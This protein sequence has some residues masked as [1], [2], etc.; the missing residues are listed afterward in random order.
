MFF[1]RMLLCGSGCNRCDSPCVHTSGALDAGVPEETLEEATD[2][3]DPKEQ[4]VSILLEVERSSNRSTAAGSQ[5][6]L[7]ALRLE[8]TQLKL[9]ALRKRAMA[10]S[11]DSQALDE[12]DDSDDPKAAVVALL[13]E[14]HRA[15]GAGAALE[16]AQLLEEL[17]P[18]KLSALRKRA[19]AGGV[20]SAAIEAV[21]D[22]DDPKE[23]LIELLI[24]QPTRE[25]A[26]A[27]VPSARRPH[28]GAAAESTPPPSTGGRKQAEAASLVPHGKHVM[29]SYQWDVQKEVLEV[30]SKL[31]G[32]RVNSW[33]DVD[34]GMQQ[35]LYDS[36]AEGVQNAC[37]VVCFMTKAYET[38]ENCRLELQFAKQL[39]VPIVP[40]LAETGYTASGWLGIVTAGA[41]WVPLAEPAAF[42]AGVRQLVQ[43]I[44]IAVPEEELQP[45][46]H[47]SPGDALSIADDQLFTP[48]EV[49]A[50][51]D[52]LRTDLDGTSMKPVAA[53]M[54]SG[55]SGLCQL[56]AGVGVLLSGLRVS[57]EMQQ[58]AKA[59]V[60]PRSRARVGFVGMGGVGKT[61][62]SAWLVRREDVRQQFDQIAW[63]PLGQ[64]PNVLKCQ[65]LLY[66]QLTG[67]EMVPGLTS[68]QRREKLQRAMIGVNVLVVLDDL[69]ENEHAHA[70][71]LIDESTGAKVLISSRVR[72]LL[73][74]ADIVDIGLPSEDEAISMLMA[75]AGAPADLEPPPEARDVVRFCKCLPLSI[76]IAGKLVADL[77]FGD[78]N[79]D[80]AGVLEML[81]DEFEQNGQTRTIE[82][83]VIAASLRSIGGARRENIVNLFMAMALIPEDVF[84][85]LDILAM[86][87]E[88]EVSG[89]D[90]DGRGSVGGSH[91]P[92]LLKLRRWLKIL[93]DR[94]LVLG[95]VDRPSLHDIPRDFCIGQHTANQ[96]EA[97]HRRLVDIFRS[98]RPVNVHGI[99]RWDFL[100]SPAA[101]YVHTYAKEHIKHGRGLE[102]WT[103][104]VLLDMPQDDLVLAAARTVDVEHLASSAADA[105]AKGEWWNSARRWALVRYLRYVEEGLMAVTEPVERTLNALDQLEQTCGQKEIAE[106]VDDIE[107]IRFEQLIS[108]LLTINTPLVL[109]RTPDVQ[110]ALQT[111]VAARNP[112]GAAI[113]RNCVELMPIL[114]DGNFVRCGAIL[115]GTCT[116][117]LEAAKTALDSNTRYRALLQA[118]NQSVLYIDILLLQDGF[119]WDTLFGPGGSN[120]MEASRSYSF[121]KIHAFLIS[122]W[123]IDS[124]GMTP[125]ASVPLAIHFEDMPAAIENMVRDDMR[126][127]KE[128]MQPCLIRHLLLI[129]HVIS[130]G[131]TTH[132]KSFFPSLG[133][134]IQQHPQE[135]EI[136]HSKRRSWHAHDW[137]STRNSLQVS[138][139]YTIY[140]IQ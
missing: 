81:Q 46:A 70:L 58:L 8:L 38:S 43:Q 94:S 116:D 130:F 113:L 91:R 119:G 82:E 1:C 111:A 5:G 86:I 85:P 139:S 95:T 13:L 2:A 117:L 120:I 71:D 103:A 7:D 50:E 26:V 124:V 77:Q 90:S 108:L 138:P 69:W 40:V 134:V 125:C 30:Q 129:V 61:T 17:T 67:A 96:L 107:E 47:G 57:P 52:R 45:A 79:D 10:E 23:A 53:D 127:T 63:I 34:G 104:E 29:L 123:N 109:A 18:M 100:I 28:F 97:A 25:A 102:D 99:Q 19:L 35:N 6:M 33:V 48:G 72:A 132:L 4:V 105:D 49:R 14:K 114:G 133:T 65:E 27:A 89:N 76:G 73:A 20:E 106:L 128:M 12:A 112:C 131:A 54:A 80:W 24:Q 3:A 51:L 56:P 137:V 83:S 78:V 74:G 93:I 11:V 44:R 36:M 92:S 88:A 66:L 122:M 98:S 135:Y 32:Q 55:S 16:Q 115:L 37:C 68:E 62:I 121:D 31:R 15:A 136:F 22:H 39:G 59:I 9:S 101:Q 126:R 60:S 140:S 21:Y 84:A 110:R 41:L 87:Y 118:H 75:A 64:Q 42:D